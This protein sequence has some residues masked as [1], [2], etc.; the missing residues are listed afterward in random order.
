M[1]AHLYDDDGRFLGWCYTHN[2]VR[3]LV[4][5]EEGCQHEHCINLRKLTFSAPAVGIVPGGF[6]DTLAKRRKQDKALE[7]YA[8]ARKNGLQPRNTEPGAVAELEREM[9][10]QARALEKLEAT[11]SDTSELK[12]HA[13]VR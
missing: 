5:G 12:T 4:E 10:S 8:Q 9:E 3:V 1:S 13:G 2:G 7:E 6:N 11:G